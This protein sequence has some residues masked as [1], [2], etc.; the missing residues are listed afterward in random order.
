MVL[1]DLIRSH[2]RSTSCDQTKPRMAE[3]EGGNALLRDHLTRVTRVA[4]N[5][6]YISTHRC[7]KCALY[8][9][10]INLNRQTLILIKLTG[11][12]YRNYSD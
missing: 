12:I 11:F 1:T 3:H 2:C 7:L 10:N 9:F 6:T 4:Y 5:T 8:L